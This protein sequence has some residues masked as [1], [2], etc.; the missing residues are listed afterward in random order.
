MF[1]TLGRTF[2]RY[3]YSNNVT[4]ET[5]W[6]YPEETATSSEDAGRCERLGSRPS[7]TEVSTNPAKTDSAKFDASRRVSNDDVILV[8][9]SGPAEVGADAV[10]P[11]PVSSDLLS[12]AANPPPPPPS[13]PPPS[14][15]R[16]SSPPPP[17]SPEPRFSS[18]MD[19]EEQSSE[20]DSRA[21]EDQCTTSTSA[22][23]DRM[24][25][26]CDSRPLCDEIQGSPTKPLVGFV[27]HIRQD[28]PVD[29]PG[30]TS[31]GHSLLQEGLYDG[32]PMEE[33][34][35]SAVKERK[36][37]KDKLVLGGGLS[38]KKKNVTSLV[39]KWQK[40]QDDVSKEMEKERSKQLKLAELAGKAAS[41]KTNQN[42]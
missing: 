28:D 40:I 29:A 3:F 33:S 39:E 6:A 35:N 34:T 31:T 37:K 21:A 18:R 26:T 8:H 5:S 19:V 10:I 20:E 16:S 30:A 41:S 36:K 12:L 13:T 7:Y 24:P 32:V 42:T 25:P 17:P 1:L 4:S 22:G 2:K 14:S 27:E 23:S 38:L 15:P 9:V 11:I